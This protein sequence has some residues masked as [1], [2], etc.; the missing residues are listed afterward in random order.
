[1]LGQLFGTA[2]AEGLWSDRARIAG[3][4][5][6]EAALARA[7]AA[8]S[9]IPEA[10]VAPIGHACRAE[11]YDPDELSAAIA[12]AG[13]PAIPLVR[14]LTLKV[15]EENPEAARYVHWGATSQDAMDT[16]LVLQLR[17]YLQ[18]LEETLNALAAALAQR[19][20]AERDTV[21]AGR[22][23]LQ[24]GPPVTF[25]LKAAGWLDAL[26]RHRQ[27]LAELKPRLLTLQFGGAVGTLAALGD[28]GLAVARTLAADL[29]L[30]LP[31]V[32]WHAARD[33]IGEI[34]AWLG[35]LCGGLGKMARD[36][37]LMMQHEVGEAS[38]GG[39][40][41]RGGSS[42][43]AHKRNP[44]S[45]SVILAAAGETPALVAALLAAQPQEHER[46][47][48]NWQVEW[49]MLPRL[50]L[51]TLGAARRAEELLENLQLD[52]A[53]MRQNLEATRGLIFA[54]AVTMALAQTLGKQQAH[55]LIER[56]TRQATAE[57]RHLKEVL[58]GQADVRSVLDAD[59]LA[60]L[61]LPENYLGEAG[62]F[63]DA[64]VSRHR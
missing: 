37:S 18:P 53:R 10:A 29:D 6:F 52:R 62:R 13:N 42:T 4:L 12:E 8:E 14:A 47:L 1:M 17:R 38:E 27:R 60:R 21:M 7:E 59:A 9:V 57:G 61:F 35:L 15:A 51:V 64:V 36:L 23:W 22:T 32:P 55:G 20:R 40:E 2:D 54:E 5:A 58:A 39:A 46:G 30:T 24:Q 33:R 11:L 25:G 28:R 3:M 49:Q 63:V 31:A 45:C 56:A 43:M 26:D 19:A 44:L 50:A 48:G 41:G 16:G 34:A